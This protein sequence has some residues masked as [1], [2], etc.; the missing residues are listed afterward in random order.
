MEQRSEQDT[1]MELLEPV[2]NR[3]ERFVLAMTR[4][5]DVA[6]DIIHETVAIAWQQFASL[7]QKKAFLSYLFTIAT[8]THAHYVRQQQRTIVADD[9]FWAY[10]SSSETSPEVV[11]DYRALY[12][13][14][15]KL[16]EQQR[17]AI[18]M[19]ELL[20]F[21]MKEVQQVQG[22]TLISV[23]VRV[24]RA[25]KKLAQ[26]LGATYAEKRTAKSTV[27]PDSVVA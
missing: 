19:F 10:M 12:D 20:G 25:R 21:S 8:R 27:S 3:L 1:F 14:I 15:D 13:A 9:D 17:E 6:K 18:I 24:S 4:N 16:P 5:R 26:L 23:K 22:G 2:Y 11:A 7:R